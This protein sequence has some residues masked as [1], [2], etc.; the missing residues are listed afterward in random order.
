MDGGAEG[1]GSARV[2]VAVMAHPKRAVWAEALAEQLQCQV[3]WDRRNNVWDTATRAWESHDPLATHHLVVQDDALLCSNLLA[4]LPAIAEA[5]PTSLISLMVS[6]PKFKPADLRRYQAA[7]AAGERWVPVWR[8]LPGVALML[9]VRDIP[10]ML[11]FG[12]RDGSPHDDVKIMS[13]YRSRQLPAWYTVPSLVQ[14][15]DQSENPSLVSPDKGWRPRMSSSWV[16]PDFD[17]ATLEWGV[18]SSVDPF[19]PR[20]FVNAQTGRFVIVTSAAQGVEMERS[21]R[22]VEV[23]LQAEQVASQ[24]VRRA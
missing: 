9:T 22:W 20:A 24:D 8:G 2:S 16:G 1:G 10:A 23:D 3:V 12:H 13:F 17:A 5:R 6:D 11:K 15:R 19:A 21:A 4:A 7:L 18:P 14:H